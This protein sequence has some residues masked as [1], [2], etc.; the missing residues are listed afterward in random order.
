MTNMKIVAQFSP[1]IYKKE[2]YIE[3]TAKITGGEMLYVSN[4]SKSQ[5]IEKIIG[6]NV[7]A[8]GRGLPFPEMSCIFTRRKVYTPHFNVVGVTARSRILRSRLWNKYDKIIALTKY[9]KKN[10]IKEGIKPNK[11]EILPLY[12]DYKRYQKTSGA[13]SF[14]NKYGIGKNEPFALV[15]GLREGKNSD[16]IAKACVKSGVKCVMVGKKSKSEL[17]RGEGDWLLPSKKLLQNTNDNIIL[18]GKISDRELLSAFN[19]ATIYVN[20]SNHTFECFSLSTYQCAASGTPLCLPDFGVFDIFKDSA[21]FHNNRNSNQL[22]TNIKKY[23]ED[24]E[25]RK[26]NAKKAR[27]TAKLFDYGPVRKIYEEFYQKLG[28]I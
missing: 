13:K 15:V 21:L 17:I 2:N 16:I 26:R 24:K 20:S 6:Q 23:L 1:D 9:A 22:A 10:F 12:I 11:V 19:T 7:H 27:K 28:L 3:F 8:H 14:R 25:L 5:I 18:T 4:F